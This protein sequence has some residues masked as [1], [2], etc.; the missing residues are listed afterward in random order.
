MH[1]RQ[2]Q[3]TPRSTVARVLFAQVRG[4][5]CIFPKII[6]D[7]TFGQSLTDTALSGDRCNTSYMALARLGCI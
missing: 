5:C 2:G 1:H 3:N 7:L 4:F 6:P